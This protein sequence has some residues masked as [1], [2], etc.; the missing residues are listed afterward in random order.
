[1]AARTS[2]KTEAAVVVP[3]PLA[4]AGDDVRILVAARDR[5][6]V[7]SALA[8]A[9]SDE[10]ATAYAIDAREAWIAAEH[11]GKR[12]SV[13][14]AMAA[15]V[16]VRRGLLTDGPKPKNAAEGVLDPKTY[17]EQWITPKHPEGVSRQMVDT[18]IRAGKAFLGWGV[19]PESKEGKRLL[20]GLA[21][22]KAWNATRKTLAEAI[23][24]EPDATPKAVAELVTA[25]IAEVTLAEAEREA[26]AKAAREAEKAKAAKELKESLAK[27]S[28]EG[29]KAPEKLSDRVTVAEQIIAGLRPSVA[30][31]RAILEDLAARIALALDDEA[32]AS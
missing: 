19:D 2:K 13:Y 22:S 11:E 6:T 32:Q 28:A 17:G 30:A 29:V 4:E 8:A 31:E 25:K 10:A 12:A 24:E 18:W 14:A 9:E 27:K 23:A 7:E 16:A 1:M 21:Q 5:F 3:K 26:E 15:A 20:G